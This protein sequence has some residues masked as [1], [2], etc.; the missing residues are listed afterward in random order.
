MISKRRQPWGDLSTLGMKLRKRRAER[1]LRQV[2][3]AEELSICLETYIHWERDKTNPPVGFWPRIVEFL[4]YD[5]SS[6]SGRSLGERLRAARR[7]KGLSRRAAAE[8]LG[9]DETTLW[10]W[11]DNRRAPTRPQDKDVVEAFLGQSINRARTT[12]MR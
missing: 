5:P 8:A 7:S 2:D 3:V 1:G 4:G 6:K 12:R 9:V 10:R 11:E